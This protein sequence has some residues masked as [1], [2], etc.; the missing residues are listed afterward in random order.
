MMIIL[1]GGE[2]NEKY[3]LHNFYSVDIYM[4]IVE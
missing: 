4:D 3:H 2:G 1:N